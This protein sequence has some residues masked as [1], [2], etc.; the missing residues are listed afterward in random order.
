MTR[1]R[2]GL[3][4]Y[5]GAVLLATMVHRIDVL[6]AL[7]AVALAVSGRR[8]LSTMRRSFRT[9]AIFNA[10]VTVSYIAVALMEGSQWWR[11]VVLIN[12]RVF[13][14]AVL[15]TILVRRV[16][17]LRALSFSRSLVYLMSVA[18]GQISMFRRTVVDF[19][20]AFRSRVVGRAT[21]RDRYRHAAATASFLM[22]RAVQE[23]TEVTLAMKARGFFDD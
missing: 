8:V 18:T 21:V 1:D 13:L 10:V 17:L 6:A 2:W 9:I 19:R 7:L 16:N 11:V 20:L 15:T 14:L 3:V 22:A 4:L 5:S 12:L 23:T